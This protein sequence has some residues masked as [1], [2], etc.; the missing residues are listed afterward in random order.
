M[1]QIENYTFNVNVFRHT[2]H[3]VFLNLICKILEPTDCKVWKS[4]AMHS[5][6]SKS[7]NKNTG[8]QKTILENTLS[9]S[10]PQLL[11]DED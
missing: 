11:H 8:K 10:L 6:F 2:S 7:L 5:N 3:Y 9:L 1:L 4:I